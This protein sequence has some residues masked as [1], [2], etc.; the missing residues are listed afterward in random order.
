MEG[1]HKVNPPRGNVTS[2][3]STLCWCNSYGTKPTK[4]PWFWSHGTQ[5][6]NLMHGEVW[7]SFMQQL[8]CR[9]AGQAWSKRCLITFPYGAATYGISFPL[10]MY[11]SMENGIWMI[12]LRYFPM[13]HWRCKVDTPQ[14]LLSHGNTLAGVWFGL[15]ECVTRET[16]CLQRMFTRVL[17]S[18][19]PQ[20]LF[21]TPI[22]DI[23]LRREYTCSLRFSMLG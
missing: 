12:G 1:L 5:Y 11:T 10:V 7:A 15:V 16:P 19:L 6:A 13:L 3:F 18:P 22:V 2:R 17:Y 8:I 23:S 9:H 20:L 4:N 14:C 21:L